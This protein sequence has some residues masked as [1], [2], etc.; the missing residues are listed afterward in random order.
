[1]SLP[2]QNVFDRQRP[3]QC[4]RCGRIGMPDPNKF[5]CVD[6]CPHNDNGGKPP[7]GTPP[8]SGPGGYT[9]TPGG[10]NGSSVPVPATL[11]PNGNTQFSDA[12]PSNPN[13]NGNMSAH[14]DRPHPMQS[15]RGWWRQTW[16][17]W[18]KDCP[19]VGAPYPC[20]PYMNPHKP[21]EVY[22]CALPCDK[23]NCRSLEEAVKQ[24]C[25]VET[26]LRTIVPVAVGAEVEFS[27]EV[28]WWFQIQKIQNLGDQVNATFDLID[29]GYGQSNYNLEIRQLLINGVAV[30]QNGIDVR[31]WNQGLFSDKFY[32]MP[33]TGLNDPLRL[34][35]L[36]VGAV[37]AD[38]ELL[39]G[40]PAVLQIG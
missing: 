7:N 40:G 10:G 17:D 11:P 21:D 25:W 4:S 1:M 15:D 20:Y 22:G 12:T 14:P 38:L 6:T 28:K 18:S 16:P 34:T 36:N 19:P 13:G 32:P 26:T 31:R 24:L 39:V 30:P 27:I 8:S 23:M 9:A 3:M 2:Q 35:F 33:A 29:I 37:P 5:G